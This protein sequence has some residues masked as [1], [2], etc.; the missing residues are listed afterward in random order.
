[1]ETR[2]QI[3]VLRRNTHEHRHRACGCE[4]KT[5]E[6]GALQRTSFDIVRV[7]TVPKPIRWLRFRSAERRTVIFTSPPFPFHE[8]SYDNP[9]REHVA[10]LSPSKRIDTTILVV[11]ITI[12]TKKSGEH[13]CCAPI[14]HK[15]PSKRMTKLVSQLVIKFTH[16]VGRTK[17]CLSSSLGRKHRS[18]RRVLLRAGEL[19][20]WFEKKTLYP[21]MLV[22]SCLRSR[23][24]NH[25]S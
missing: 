22:V 20:P 2:V 5:D 3:T 14:T 15:N 11:S 24:S 4:C 9:K 6:G 17:F 23:P 7:A 18:T 10:L 12:L 13:W 8:S 19:F 21:C 1:M 25:L 16:S